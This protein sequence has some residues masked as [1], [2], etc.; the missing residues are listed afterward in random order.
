MLLWGTSLSEPSVMIIFLLWPCVCSI[1]FTQLFFS[2]LSFFGHWKL[3]ILKCIFKL[4]YGQKCRRGGVENLH[5]V[6]HFP[7]RCV[8]E[9][10]TRVVKPQADLLVKMKFLSHIVV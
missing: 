2:A 10:Q 7:N 4:W 5:A 6:F 8:G 3:R 1:L 9:S